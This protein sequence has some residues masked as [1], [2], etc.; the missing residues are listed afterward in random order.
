MDRSDTRYA[1]SG[2]VHVAYRVFGDGPF[3]LVFAMGMDYPSVEFHDHAAGAGF[4]E[5]T[6]RMRVVRFDKRGTGASDRVSGVPSLEERM[7]DVRA[8]MDA[9]GVERAA[10]LGHVDGAAMAILFAATYPE[11]VFALVL[12]QGKPRFVYAPDFPW[13]PTREAYE[14]GTQGWLGELLDSAQLERAFATRLQRPISDAEVRERVR[15]TRLTMSPGSLL[16]LRR[17]NMDIDVRGALSTIQV[18]TLIVHRSA[19][20]DDASD[21]SA[22]EIARY[23]ATRIPDSRLM[24]VGRFDWMP[25]KAIADFL[26]EAWERR[27]IERRR[28]LATVLFTDLVDSTAKAAELGG[29]WPSLLTEHNAAIRREL[30]RFRGETIDTAGDGFF[31]SGFDGPAR[32][33]RCACA[34]RDAVT[35]LGLGIRIGV[36]TGEC[37]VV[38]GKLAGLAVAVGA[39]VAAQADAGEVLVSGTVKDLVAG[40]GIAFDARGLSE[41]KGLGEWPLYSV[42][43]LG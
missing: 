22:K 36:H 24:E 15:A 43:G 41:L 42:A 25:F 1:R 20:L 3:D 6:E 8:V 33:I 17:M 31:A 5:L 11:R 27:A 30:A 13:V 32:A 40:S 2:D 28:V 4:N 19:D 12:F 7:D 39:R 18:P 38:D 37:D 29:A 34:I 16:A 9:V 21:T 14:Q 26:V 23:M 35:S 10:L